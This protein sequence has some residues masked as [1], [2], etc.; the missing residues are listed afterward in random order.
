LAINR[1]GINVYRLFGFYQC[2]SKGR[3]M[4]FDRILCLNQPEREDRRQQA[5]EEFERVGLLVDWFYSIPDAEPWL[6]FCLSQRGMIEL[7]TNCDKVLLLED[8]VIFRDF[9][10]LPD[11]MAQ[12]PEDWDILYLGANVLD[13]NPERHSTNLW[14]IRAAWTSHAIAYQGPILREIA[15]RY[16]PYTCGMY[17]DWLKREILPICRAYVCSPMLAYQRPGHSDLWGKWADYTGA[18]EHGN[19]RMK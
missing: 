2:L 1:R 5:A 18:F 11:V 4:I 7:V 12:L 8:D 13:E 16:D 10:T 19:E 6:S 15:R 14:R 17:D 9:E 3:N